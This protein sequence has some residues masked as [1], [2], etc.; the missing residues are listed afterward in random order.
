MLCF[1]AL[2]VL[3]V[4]FIW[5]WLL[6][7]C[8]LRRLQGVWLYWRREFSKQRARQV[9]LLIILHPISQITYVLF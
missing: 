4:S 2:L 3:Y 7:T 8:R 1:K 6:C 9:M 5:I